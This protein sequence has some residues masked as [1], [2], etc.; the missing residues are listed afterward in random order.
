MVEGGDELLMSAISR[1]G[2][3]S[4]LVVVPVVPLFQSES[5]S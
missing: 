1:A 2:V 4:H 3:T 5:T